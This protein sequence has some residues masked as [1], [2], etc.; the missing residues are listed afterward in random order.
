MMILT[1]L[2]KR[3]NDHTIRIYWRTGLVHVGILDINIEHD[4]DDKELIAELIAIEHLIFKAQVFQSRGQSCCF[5][6]STILIK[7]SWCNLWLDD[8]ESTLKAYLSM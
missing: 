4:C 3:L 5:K 8:L 7:N 6:L 2:P 1:T